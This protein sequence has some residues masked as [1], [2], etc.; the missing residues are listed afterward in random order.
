M[1]RHQS[2]IRGI[3]WAKVQDLADELVEGGLSEDEALDEIAQF[4][5]E[6]VDLSDFVPAPAGGLVEIVDRPIIR[7]ALDLVLAVAAPVL[8]LVWGCV[9]NLSFLVAPVRFTPGEVGTLQSMGRVMLHSLAN[10]AVVGLVVAPAVGV[11]LGTARLLGEGALAQLA[12][13]GAACAFALGLVGA[14]S[15]LGGRALRRL[16]PSCV[17]A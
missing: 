15:L 8:A 16:D 10:L 13:L 2:M 14:L 11:S 9:E 1:A 3:P 5:D 4:L 7:A 12:G 6:L 17:L